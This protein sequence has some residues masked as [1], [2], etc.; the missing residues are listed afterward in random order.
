MASNEQDF[1]DYVAMGG[2]VQDEYTNPPVEATPARET[3]CTKVHEQMNILNMRGIWLPNVRVTR[4]KATSTNPGALYLKAAQG[5][6]YL[7]KITADGELRTIIAL[8]QIV[9][10][11][12][13]FF[14]VKG[15]DYLAQVG[16]ETGQCCFCGLELTDPESVE[17]GYGPVCAKKHGLPHS[18]RHG[19]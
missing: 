3:V 6:D 5:G 15:A 10:D 11:E 7:G 16:K 13:R 1:N 17:V 19:F 14:A 18:N 9:R 12:L 2:L 4:A 8:P